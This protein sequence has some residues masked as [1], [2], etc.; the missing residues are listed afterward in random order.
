M[1]PSWKRMHIKP[2]FLYLDLVVNLTVHKG[3]ILMFTE[4]VFKYFQGAAFRTG[5]YHWKSI[6]DSEIIIIY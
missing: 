1:T 4:G 6:V 2:S 5:I 3:D